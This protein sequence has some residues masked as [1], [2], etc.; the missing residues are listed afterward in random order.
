MFEKIFLQL[1]NMSFTASLVII[2]VVIARL[3]FKKAPKIFSYCLWAV[4]LFRLVCPFSFESV[5]SLLPANTTPIPTEIIYAPVPQI[6]TGI[7]PIDNMVNP[8]LPVPEVGA[9]VNPFKFGRL[10][11]KLCGLR[12]L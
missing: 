4:V 12:V 8:V 9:S 6:E 7:V 1:L 10:S 11:V 3:V 5:L 2:F